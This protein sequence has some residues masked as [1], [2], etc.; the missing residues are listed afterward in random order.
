MRAR[1][2]VWNEFNCILV[3]SFQTFGSLIF[4]F[5][6]LMTATALKT[7]LIVDWSGNIPKLSQLSRLPLPL[8]A[9]PHPGHGDTKTYVFHRKRIQMKHIADRVAQLATPR[10]EHI[11]NL[12]T[13]QEKQDAVDELFEK[14]E[15]QL[16]DEELILGR[17]PK[18]GFWVERAV[19][20]F[21]EDYQAQE[22]SKATSS[23][24]FME[25]KTSKDAN[26]T[27]TPKSSEISTDPDQITTAEA[28]PEPLGPY[29]TFK[30]D[31]E[32]VPIFMDLYQGEEATETVPKI[33]YPLKTHPYDKAGRMVE[34]WELSAHKTSKRIMMRQCMRKISQTLEENESSRIFVSGRKGVGKVSEQ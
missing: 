29:P 19:E 25:K 30:Q 13:W 18:F 28:L 26:L 14:I 9:E 1:E 8:P 11:I 27:E 12:P 22:Q 15:F 21:L 16:K 33:L 23:V 2:S 5:W 17:H 32:A 4:L 34:E 24:A 31:A 6:F 10:M 20:E 3:R 7:Y